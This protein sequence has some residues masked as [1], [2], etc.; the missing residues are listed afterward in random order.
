MHKPKNRRIKESKNNIYLVLD[1][2]SANGSL[3]FEILY[4]NGKSIT[5]WSFKKSNK[6]IEKLLSTI[7]KKFKSKKF[8]IKDI[9]GLI[10][11]KRGASFS[12]VRGVHSIANSLSWSLNIPAVAVEKNESDNSIISQLDKQKHPSLLVP[13]YSRHQNIT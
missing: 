11:F 6:S 5:K 8:K 7:D 1:P 4:R 10:I 13:K 12:Q 3:R 9:K 2:G